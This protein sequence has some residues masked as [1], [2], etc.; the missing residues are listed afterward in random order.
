MGVRAVVVKVSVAMAA[1]VRAVGRMEAAGS[2]GEVWAVVVRVVVVMAAVGGRAE[3][4]AVL[5]EMAATAGKVVPEKV[6]VPTE[7]TAVAAAVPKAV[8]KGSMACT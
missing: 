1:E 2:V 6:A 3:D 7:A 8:Q 4:S 5:A